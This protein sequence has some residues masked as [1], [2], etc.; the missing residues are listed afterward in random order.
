MPWVLEQSTV[1]SGCLLLA[2]MALSFVECSTGTWQMDAF[3]HAVEVAS[4]CPDCAARLNGLLGP[5]PVLHIAIHTL[6]QVGIYLFLAALACLHGNMAPGAVRRTEIRWTEG[7]WFGV[8]YCHA[9]D[10]RV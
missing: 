7:R 9:E 8:P 5:V 2:A 3:A 10:K 1:F 4:G 6:E